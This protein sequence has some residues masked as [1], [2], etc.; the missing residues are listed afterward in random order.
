MNSQLHEI[1]NFHKN[2]FQTI[3]P[4]C[5]YPSGLV[6]Y[7]VQSKEINRFLIRSKLNGLAQLQSMPEMKILKISLH[8]RLNSTKSVPMC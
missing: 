8:Q 7:T 1:N 2:N 4:L 3:I 6:N 5:F